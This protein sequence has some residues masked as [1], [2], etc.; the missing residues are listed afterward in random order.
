MKK[1]FNWIAVCLLLTVSVHS[2][3][4]PALALEREEVQPR[5]SYCSSCGQMTLTHLKVGGPYY[6][7]GAAVRHTAC[8]NWGYRRSVVEVWRYKCTNCSFENTYE[9]TIREENYCPNCGVVF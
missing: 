1:L 6:Y 8:G 2:L 4:M 3:S 7:N 5:A 9:R